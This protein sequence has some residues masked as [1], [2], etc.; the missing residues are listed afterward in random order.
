MLSYQR[1]YSKIPSD[2]PGYHG[3]HRVAKS[4]SWR[5]SLSHSITFMNQYIQRALFPF[6]KVKGFLFPGGLATRATP[7]WR[8]V[9]MGTFKAE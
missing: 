3:S 2:L 1:R 8:S 4:N 7:G 9:L 5:L 6:I